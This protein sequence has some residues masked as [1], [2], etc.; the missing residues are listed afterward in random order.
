[1]STNPQPQAEYQQRK[2]LYHGSRVQV[3]L[4][5]RVVMYWCAY[6]VAIAAF[7]LI[8]RIVTGPARIFYTHFED[9]WFHFGP[10]VIA[11]FLLLPFLLWD[12][13]KLSNRF[14]GPLTRLR[15]HFRMGACGEEVPPIHFREGDF[16]HDVSEEFNAMI[17]ELQKRQSEEEEVRVTA[18]KATKQS[19]S[20]KAPLPSLDI[21][22]SSESSNAVT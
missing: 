14:V 20:Y 8:W 6:M 17:A 21:P 7:V 1:M 3:A 10:A 15:K 2:Q 13:L 19:T 4:L 11:S 22:T 5:A 9:M 12:T 18:A 16:W